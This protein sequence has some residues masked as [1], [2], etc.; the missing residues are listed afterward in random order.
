MRVQRG[1][2][3]PRTESLSSNFWFVWEEDEAS[4]GSMRKSVVRG[5]TFGNRYLRGKFHS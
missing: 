2:F 5:Q 3:S 1:N 4:N